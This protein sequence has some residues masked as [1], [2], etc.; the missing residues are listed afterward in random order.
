MINFYQIVERK[1]GVT[2]GKKDFKQNT[3][4]NYIPPEPLKFP[5]SSVHISTSESKFRIERS[6]IEFLK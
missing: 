4:E 1:K 3:V 6:R 2:D 5:K